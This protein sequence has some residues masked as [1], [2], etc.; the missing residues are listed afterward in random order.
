MDNISASRTTLDA[1]RQHYAGVGLTERLKGALSVFGPADQQLSVSQLGPVDQF[2]TRGLEATAEL[3]HLAELQPDMHVLDV[4]SGLGGPA[5]FIAENFGCT[6][7][8]VD[9]SEAYVDAARYLTERTGQSGQ[10]SFIVANALELPF[11]DGAFDAVFLQHVAMNI[12]DRAGL[13]REIRRILSPNG[14]FATYDV[15]LKDGDPTYPLPW[16]ASAEGSF[17]MTADDTCR[18]IEEAGFRAVLRGDDSEAAKSWITKLQSSGPPPQPNLGTVIGRNMLEIMTNL[19]RAI[20]QGRL[21][22]LTAVFE[23]R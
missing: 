10:I 19:G 7:T 22:I 15:V 11:D 21:G 14:R 16:S 3:A 9:L 17:L 13:Y 2:H 5:R 18:T 4:G 20:M 8:G 23:P 1:A 6:V 12:S